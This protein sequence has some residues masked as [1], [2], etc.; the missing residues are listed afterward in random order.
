[1]TTSVYIVPAMTDQAGQCR[2]VAREGSVPSARDDYRRN[3]Q[4]WKEIGIMNSQG[5]LVC[6]EADNLAAYDELKAC[7]PL[8]AGLH[9]E[10]DEQQAIAA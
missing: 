5:R 9:I 6:L 3:P 8:M 4:A 2:I 10:V 7:E 1:M